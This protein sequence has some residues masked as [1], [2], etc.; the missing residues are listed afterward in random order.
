[1]ADLVL[2]AG[3]EIGLTF[4]TASPVGGAR[5]SSGIVNLAI[6]TDI[7]PHPEEIVVTI[8]A[9]D[10]STGEAV[11]VSVAQGFHDGPDDFDGPITASDPGISDSLAV[12]VGVP[13][14]L[15][16]PGTSLLVRTSGIFRIYKSRFI[17]VVHNDNALTINN[18]VVT[19]RS[20]TRTTE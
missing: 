13:F 15:I 7:D 14:P 11:N 17:V 1:M 10:G 6:V 20:L 19:A 4:T 9:T 8:E 12:N 5:I 18:L 3:T 2:R 16:M